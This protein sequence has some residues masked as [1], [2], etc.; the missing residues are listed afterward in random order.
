MANFYDVNAAIDKPNFLGAAQQGLQFGQQQRALREQ[1]ADQQQLRQLTPQILGGDP[2]AYAQAAAI[3]Q[4]AANKAQGSGDAQLRRLEPAIAYMKRAQEQAQK[5]NNP[6]A[7]QAAWDEV[8]PYFARLSG[9]EPPAD[10]ATAAPHFDQLEMRIQM[11]KAAQNPTT[12]P[13]GFRELHM[14]ALAAGYQPG[15]PEYQNAMRVGIGTEGRAATGGFG[16]EKVV[17]ADGRERMGRTN[18]RTGVFEVYDETSGNFTPLGGPAALNGGPAPV[19]AADGFDDG[20]GA[21]VGGTRVNMGLPPQQQQSVAKAIAAME[22]AGVERSVIDAFATS[23]MAQSADRPGAPSNPALG[24][25]QAPAE[26]AFATESGQQAAQT[27]FLTEQERIKRE[28]AIEQARGIE[29]AKTEAERAAQAPKRVK[30]YEQAL[31]ASE[32]VM[33]SIDRALGMIGPMSTGF[34]G[35]RSRGIEGSPAYNL[36]AEIETVKANLG[37]DRL[38]QMRDNSPTGGALGAIAVQELVALQSTIA[39]LDPNQSDDQL[40]QNLERVKTHYQNWQSAVEQALSDE[41]RS[42]QTQQSQPASADDG[43][44]RALL[45]KY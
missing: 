4:D 29:T 24:V 44:R 23:Q 17:G 34:I 35:A 12:D 37:F 41:K 30:Q 9:H 33:T 18:P 19:P 5:T 42:G 26:K 13:T 40:R 2:A 15:T 25:S 21:V 10:F 31:Q 27:Q 43:R 3:D 36:G 45:D 38:Q 8:R 11:A 1:R 20:G 22:A 7:A 32:N 39:N 16:F 14:K 6:R 28:S